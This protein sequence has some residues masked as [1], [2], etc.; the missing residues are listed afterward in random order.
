MTAADPPSRRR[1]ARVVALVVVASVVGGLALSLVVDPYHSD[2]GGGDPENYLFNGVRQVRGDDASYH[3]LPPEWEALPAAD[4]QAL[5]EAFLDDESRMYRLSDLPPDDVDGTPTIDPAI[6]RKKA[7][8]DAED[9]IDIAHDNLYSVA[10]SLGVL[11]HPDEAPYLLNS[12]LVVAAGIVF[13]AVGRALTGSR[14]GWVAGVLL[15]ALPATL[16]G[17]RETRT[18]AFATL[19]LVVFAWVTIRDRGRTAWPGLLLVALWMTRHEYMIPLLVYLGWAGLRRRPGS[20]WVVGSTVLAAYLF[21]W[22]PASPGDLLP[23]DR[24]FFAAIPHLPAWSLVPLFAVLWLAADRLGPGVERAAAGLRHLGADRRVHTAVWGGLIAVAVVAELLRQ[25]LEVR[26]RGFVVFRGAALS[27]LGVLV[28]TVGWPILVLGLVGLVTFGWRLAGRAP[29][30]LAL[31]LAPHAMVL[32][33]TGTSGDDIW[34]VARR[35]QAALYP[36]LLVGVALV[37]V[38]VAR[39]LPRPA[40]SALGAGALT[41]VCLLG[42]V[43]PFDRL[44]PDGVE[45]GRDDVAAFHE[46]A[47]ELPDDALVVLDDTYGS[48]S[49]QPTLRFFHGLWSV[50]AWDEDEAAAVLPT[51]LGAADRPVL[52]EESLVPL[53]EACG[54]TATDEVTELPVVHG[55][56]DGEVV[57]LVALEPGT[58]CTA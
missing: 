26:E 20:W 51:A 24:D 41:A 36:V 49:A 11:V 29:W 15:V 6:A 48:M 53:V 28:D 1:A 10:L 37:L 2:F 43:G 57:R 19:L 7:V 45:P 9:R 42:L 54:A 23:G 50:V 56:S 14:W 25:T 33:R 34:N 5:R 16:D 22:G 35:F 18:E 4:R 13:A 27:T 39:R 40:P 58:V 3:F 8:V 38:E 52:V 21:P 12:I 31:V 44:P 46:V 30:I 55:L 17:A 47:D 32:I